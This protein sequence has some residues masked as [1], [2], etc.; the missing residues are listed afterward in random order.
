MLL[1]FVAGVGLVVGQAAE[2]STPLSCP[3]TVSVTTIAAA[4]PPAKAE[5]AKSEHRFSRPSLY[6][7]TPGGKEFEL[8]PDNANAKTRRIEQ[9]WKLSDHRDKDLFIRCRYEGTPA[10]VVLDVP[11]PLTTCSFSFL[12]VPGKPPV[13]PIFECK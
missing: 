7:G 6:N 8:A 2:R 10:T 4:K 13:Q 12:N 1:A 3:A 9:S 5:P 11:K